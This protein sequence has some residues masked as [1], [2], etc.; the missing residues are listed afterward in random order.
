MELLKL[1]GAKT[2]TNPE[3]VAVNRSMEIGTSTSST[4]PKS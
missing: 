4:A 3:L 1:G 2:W